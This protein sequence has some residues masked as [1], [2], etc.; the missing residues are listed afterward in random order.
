MWE[1]KIDHCIPGPIPGPGWPILIFG[2]KLLIPIGVI[3]F[4]PWAY[5]LWIGIVTWGC[6]CCDWCPTPIGIGPPCI[7]KGLMGVPGPMLLI[8]TCCGPLPKPMGTFTWPIL[9]CCIPTFITCGSLGSVKLVRR[10]LMA[11]KMEQSPGDR[12]N[13]WPYSVNRLSINPAVC[14]KGLPE[15]GPL[16]E[17]ASRRSAN[18]VIFP[19]QS[20]T[21]GITTDDPSAS[22]GIPRR[23][24]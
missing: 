18:W 20:Y 14:A 10:S 4:I 24:I 16:F 9:A 22:A 7:C 1:Q 17:A 12:A 2:P 13:V 3:E 11:G 15:L 21:K 8:P 6:G 5:G 19:L 23:L